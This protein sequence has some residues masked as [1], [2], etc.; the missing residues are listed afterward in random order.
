MLK[1]RDYVI[2]IEQELLEEGLIRDLILS[3]PKLKKELNVNVKNIEKK[4][5]ADKKETIY[6][7]GN[8]YDIIYNDTQKHDLVNRIN[9]RT[10]TISI[11]D[12][13]NFY[14]KECVSL[15]HDEI[16][17]NKNHY[18][19]KIIK[20]MDFYDSINIL[21]FNNTK[22]ITNDLFK[23]FKNKTEEQNKTENYYS[24][25]LKEMSRHYNRP[26]DKYFKEALKYLNIDENK[27]SI[28]NDL[29]KK[30][31]IFFN[32]LLLREYDNKRFEVPNY[33]KPFYGF[34]IYLNETVFYFS[35][36][37]TI[38]NN[39]VFI[40]NN[41]KLHTVKYSTLKAFNLLKETSFILNSKLIISNQ[42]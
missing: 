39:N 10:Q 2:L 42:S 15:I 13:K 37:Y 8:P 6:I 41:I 20:L 36:P 18:E 9:D 4:D 19:S 33:V 30:N 27:M 17:V 7:K 21:I 11:D 16:T 35:I 23:Y 32:N 3:D 28:I 29:I 40:K 38:N 14:I 34:T 12:F 31:S 22:N 26:D 25:I 5:F 1:Y 24:I